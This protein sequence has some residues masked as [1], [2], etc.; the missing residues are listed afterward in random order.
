MI[1]ADADGLDCKEIVF[2]VDRVED[3]KPRRD[4][5]TASICRDGKDWKRATAEP[6]TARWGFLR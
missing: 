4:F 6:A 3:K 5:Y 2:S 1:V